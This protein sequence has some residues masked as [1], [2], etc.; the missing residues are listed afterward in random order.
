MSQQR[1]DQ[2]LFFVRLV[3]SRT[4]AADLIRDG[5]LR[6]NGAICAKPSA[7]LKTGDVLTLRHGGGV[8]VVQVGGFGVR[9]GPASEAQTLYTDLTPRAAPDDADR[10]AANPSRAAGQGRPTKRDRRAID[11]L[12]EGE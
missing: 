8:R 11:A 7:G 6:V 5:A 10:R 9:R 4:L 2:W 12:N 1:A 3:K